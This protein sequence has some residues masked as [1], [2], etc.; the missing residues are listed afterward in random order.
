MGCRP[1][2]VDSS[3]VGDTDCKIPDAVNC[4]LRS[5]RSV[6]IAPKIPLM[7]KKRDDCG[8]ICAGKQF[9]PTGHEG[10]SAATDEWPSRHEEHPRL[11]RL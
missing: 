6:L 3:D 2:V 4:I 5:R 8:K 1:A 7:V 11:A 9:A 10:Q